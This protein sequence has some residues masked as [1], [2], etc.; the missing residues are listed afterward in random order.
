MSILQPIVRNNYA[1]YISAA[2]LVIPFIYATSSMLHAY[3]AIR[4]PG[5][6]TGTCDTKDNKKTCCWTV[7]GTNPGV[8]K[9]R[10]TYCQ[11][12]TYYHDSSGSAYE[13]CTDP[14]K[15]T[16]QAQPKSDLQNGQNLE[17]KSKANI[18]VAPNEDNTVKG[19]T[20]QNND[21]D[22]LGSKITNKLQQKD[23]PSLE[24]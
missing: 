10:V 6:D 7:P 18:T 19:S 20:E 3:A 16:I 17:L 1:V 2:V 14:K 15:Q 22:T 23:L 24:K 4:D 11:T 9:L 8:I 13:K 21:N 5:F 12:C